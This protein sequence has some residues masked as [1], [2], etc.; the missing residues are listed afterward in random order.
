MQNNKN[1][2]L[3]NKVAI[4]DITK[5]SGKFVNGVFTVWRF[6]I[7]VFSCIVITIHRAKWF[8]TVW[9]NHRPVF[10][11]DYNKRRRKKKLDFLVLLN[12]VIKLEMGGILVF[13]STN[14]NE[15]ENVAQKS[16]DLLVPE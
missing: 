10:S 7:D 13:I 6:C 2:V 1:R 14:V 12:Q 16:F 4:S 11:V 8:E 9:R 15:N 3:N 5:H